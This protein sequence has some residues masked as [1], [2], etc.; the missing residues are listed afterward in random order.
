MT[1]T[2]V[3]A[4]TKLRL[5]A[6]TGQAITLGVQD[7]KILSTLIAADRKRIE[8]LETDIDTSEKRITSL[9]KMVHK[10]QELVAKQQRKGD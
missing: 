5:A 4:E 7:A 3:D 9:E 6:S 10:E 2:L 8:E 1:P